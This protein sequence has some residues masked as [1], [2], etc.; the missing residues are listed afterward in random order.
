MWSHDAIIG[1]TVEVLVG[2]AGTETQPSKFM[3]N[4]S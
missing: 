1:K 3:H 4:D 2:A